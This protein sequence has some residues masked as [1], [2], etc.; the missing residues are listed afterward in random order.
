MPKKNFKKTQTKTQYL[1]WEFK[2]LKEIIFYFLLLFIDRF[3]YNEL[4]K[5]DWPNTLQILGNS[6]Y[7][8]NKNQNNI[9]KI[10][11]KSKK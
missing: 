5:F 9:S 6:S 11:T 3:M 2:D 7:N 1:C 10:T 4:S 8:I